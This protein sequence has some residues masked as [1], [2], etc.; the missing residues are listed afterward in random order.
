MKCCFHALCQGG[1]L[2]PNKEWFN[3]SNF[4]GFGFWRRLLPSCIHVLSSCEPSCPYKCSA[5]PGLLH[6][7]LLISNIENHVILPD[8]HRRLFFNI[9]PSLPS[10]RK[11][12]KTPC[13]FSQENHQK[14]INFEV[15]YKNVQ[16]SLAMYKKREKNKENKINLIQC[17]YTRWKH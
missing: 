1:W 16:S 3:F 8:F 2:R 4:H 5:S 17:G 10:P 7:L 14:N 13:D 12:K 9:C 11:S 15:L 6:F